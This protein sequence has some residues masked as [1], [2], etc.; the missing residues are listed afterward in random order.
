MAHLRAFICL[1]A[2]VSL[3]IDLI[4]KSKGGVRTTQPQGLALAV[5]V[6]SILAIGTIIGPFV[7][8]HIGPFVTTSWVVL[9]AGWEGYRWSVR[10]AHP[11]IKQ[12]L[13]GVAA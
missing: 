9:F 12:P 11:L 4:Y 13:K 8:H 3:V 2:L 5:A 6:G 7:H 10:L 1:L